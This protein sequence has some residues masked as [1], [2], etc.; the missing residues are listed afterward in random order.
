MFVRQAARRYFPWMILVLSLAI[1]PELSATR[2][3]VGLQAAPL[4][5]AQLNS[6]Q[7]I[8]QLDTGGDHTCVLVASGSVKCWGNNYS[9]QLG[10]GTTS[11][12]STPVLV[13][14]LS[15]VTTLATGIEHTCAVTAASAGD[16]HIQCWGN[17]GHGQL[18]DGTTNHRSTPV[19]VN[20]LSSVSTLA[21]GGWHSCALLNDG[22]VQC[23]G[24]NDYGQLG[25]G[26]TSD[27]NTPVAVNGLSDVLA[28]AGG[29]LHTCA[30]TSSGAV[31]CWGSNSWPTGRRDNPGSQYANNCVWPERRRQLGSGGSAHLRPAERWPCPMLG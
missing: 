25:D 24:Y 5:L 18:G 19:E 4:H 11:D 27:R 16:G 17:N 31:Y 9:G 2:A 29:M 22:R 1:I 13:P 30:L 20:S 15:S 26:T 14:G 6:F 10:D 28:L 8:I 23:W 3:S 7:A 12:H 21:A